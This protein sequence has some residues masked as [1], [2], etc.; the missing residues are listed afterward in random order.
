MASFIHS[1]DGLMQGDPIVMIAYRIS[2]IPLIK[3]LKQEIPD[4]TQTWYADNA[5]DLGTYTRIETYFNLLTLQVPGH[6]Y[7]TKPSKR[8]LI[9]H[10]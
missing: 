7:Y 3:N 8:V 4:I 6:R 1:N 10:P 5:G 2:I 9:T